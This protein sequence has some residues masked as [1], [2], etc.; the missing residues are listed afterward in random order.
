M[1]GE[2]IFKSQT[3]MNALKFAGKIQDTSSCAFVVAIFVPAHL[4]L[5]ARRVA[6]H[7]NIAL[8]DTIF[9]VRIM[10]LEADKENRMFKGYVPKV[11]Q[12]MR[13]RKRETV[14]L[15][16]RRGLAEAE[17]GDYT[18]DYDPIEDEIFTQSLV[19]LLMLEEAGGGAG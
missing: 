15:C 8:V 2:K 13:G 17:A 3:F 16:V 7:A 5:K 9:E 11:E 14:P 4:D 6:A 12:L 10:N 1:I 19:Q 18:F